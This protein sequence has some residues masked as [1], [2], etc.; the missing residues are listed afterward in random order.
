[1]IEGLLISWG[2]KGAWSAF[3]PVLEDFAKSIAEDAAK[4][5]VG[6]CFGSV[7]SPLNKKPLTKAAGLA[8]KELLKLL[9]D[10][11]LDAELETR[12]LEGAWRGV[13]PEDASREGH[14]WSFSLPESGVEPLL[15]ALT[16]E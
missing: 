15:R 11:L 3:G 7:L 2:I 6:K 13:L 5:Y 1:M 10:E 14:F 12:E 8:V 9:E 16:S 4:S